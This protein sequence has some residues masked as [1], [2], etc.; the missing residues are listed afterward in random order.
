MRPANLSRRAAIRWRHASL[1]AFVDDYV[2][3]IGPFVALRTSCVWANIDFPPGGAARIETAGVEAFA[4]F[5]VTRHVRAHS[6]EK[7]MLNT[8]LARADLTGATGAFF[9]PAKN[10]STRAERPR[11]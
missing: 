7:Y 2:A 3:A 10:R 11:P 8:S 4:D 9:D 5:N 6:R 1:P